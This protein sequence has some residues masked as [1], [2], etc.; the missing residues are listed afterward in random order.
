MQ[1]H[2]DKDTVDMTLRRKYDVIKILLRQAVQ[3][4]DWTLI[5]FTL[6][7]CWNKSKI[8]ETNEGENSFLHESCERNYTNTTRV[9]IMHGMGVNTKNNDGDTCLHIAVNNVSMSIVFLLLE[10]GV[11]PF[12]ENK[13]GQQAID[14]AKCDILKDKLRKYSRRCSEIKLIKN[15]TSWKRM[16]EE[17][18]K[19]DTL[20]KAKEQEF[21]QNRK[22][23]HQSLIH[24]VVTSTSMKRADS[25]II[26]DAES[27]KSGTLSASSVT[28]D[29]TS[30]QDLDN[31]E[32]V[33]R[34][35]NTFSFKDI[36]NQYAVV[37]R[38][39]SSSK[40][41]PGSEN[42]AQRNEHDETKYGSLRVSSLYGNKKTPN[43]KRRKKFDRTQ[44][45]SMPELPIFAT[46]ESY[47]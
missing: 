26:S 1:I 3:N 40:Q 11:N 30:L 12:T 19:R 46:P 47:I 10:A 32:K 34:K 27:D 20:L 29:S 36:S 7:K 18:E 15:L 24:T 38:K 5:N 22:L 43:S 33:K 35:S 8:F 21:L 44:R 16:V 14:L 23:S 17:E 31:A 39:I 4:D 2:K 42:D 41:S 28:T 9:L 45:M 6:S 25:G 13:N 37:I